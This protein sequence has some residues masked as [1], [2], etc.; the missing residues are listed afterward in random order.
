[1]SRLKRIFAISLLTGAILTI[2]LVFAQSAKARIGADGSLRPT[3]AVSSLSRPGEF[4]TGPNAG[5]PLDIVQNFINE[6]TDALGLT[7]NDVNNFVV[8]DQYKTQH[9]GVTHVYLQQQF[10]GI[11]VFNAILNSN[12]TSD[13]RIINVGNRFVADLENKVVDSNPG[14]SPQAAVAA[15]ASSVGL[16][17]SQPLLVEEVIGGPTQAVVLSN[18]GISLESI[19]VKLAYQPTDN[20]QV[21]LA[22]DVTIYELSTV[23]WW[24]LRVDAVTGD[25]LSKVDWVVN[26][27]LHEEGG[28]ATSNVLV[29]SAQA[30]SN[31]VWNQSVPTNPDEYLV[32]AYPKEDPDDGPATLE[33]DPADPTSNPFGWHD[34]DGSAGAEYTITR[35]NNVYAD[36]DLDA[37]NTPDGNAPD[38]GAGLSFNFP[39]NLDA[40]PSTYLTSTIVNLFYWNNL[41]HDISYRYGFDE[42]SGNFQE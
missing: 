41:M 17:V 3:N 1:M 16:S 24:S 14:L 4:L 2:S 12:V 10:N 30:P 8:S 20:G 21:K 29:G 42:V 32:F 35:G 13:G 34:T 26:E 11:P 19:P 27:N 15:A 31:L 9:N 36:S 33:M 18:G 39:F 37:N 6:N 7:T 23:H 25:L 5:E 22:W 28:A 38:G 40:D